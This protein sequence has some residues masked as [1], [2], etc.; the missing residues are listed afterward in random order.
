MHKHALWT[1]LRPAGSRGRVLALQTALRVARTQAR[2]QELVPAH[3][4]AAV[5]LVRARFVPHLPLAFLLILV[6][7]GKSLPQAG[8]W[9][10]RFPSVAQAVHQ[11]TSGGAL[12]I[13]ASDLFGTSAPA[14]QVKRWAGLTPSLTAPRAYKTS[15]PQTRQRQ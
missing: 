9:F 14:A 10:R 8:L 12:P 13:R 15:D 11:V 4:V 6:L 1:W 5:W 7:G 2:R 3:D